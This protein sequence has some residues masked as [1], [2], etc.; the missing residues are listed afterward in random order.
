M[1]DMAKFKINAGDMLEI[2]QYI[3]ATGRT[4]KGETKP[5]HDDCIM[6][7][8]NNEILIRT[9]DSNQV[10]D[11]ELHYPLKSII[12]AGSIPLEI[13]KAIKDLKRFKADQEITISYGNGCVEY[14]RVKPKLHIKEQTIAEDKVHSAL[15][16]IAFIYK[17]ETNGWYGRK[18]GF[19]IENYV[20][21]DAS[22]FKEIVLDGEQIQHRSFPFSVIGNVLNV[23]VEDSDTG[24]Q[25]SREIA[26]KEIKP[27]GDL[28][29]LFSY[30][31]GNAFGQLTG[32]IEIW[33]ANS[34][35]MVIRKKS[36]KIEVVYILATVELSDKDNV[37]T[38]SKEESKAA[39]DIE[40]QAE[41]SLEDGELEESEPE[42]VPEEA[43]PS[44]EPVDVDK[45][46]AEA[47]E[48]KKSKKATK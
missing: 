13:E 26:V 11:T 35:P 27:K 19:P 32:E 38:P 47:L 17:K 23:V 14:E 25:I 37:K 7:I 2:L 12:E 16:A 5:F 3:Q 1:M 15:D 20:K 43:E 9:R 46:E 21:V 24:N 6:Q 42:D 28:K 39:D 22:E 29:S 8:G 36:D 33:L 18:K 4:I 34:G 41:E 44:G 48:K 10:L 31:F 40:K 45:L 30:G